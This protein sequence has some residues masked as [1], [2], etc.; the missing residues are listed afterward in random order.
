MAQV[1]DVVR[2]AGE[3]QQHGKADLAAM[4]YAAWI[5]KGEARLRYV[6]RFNLAVLQVESGETVSARKNLEACIQEAPTFH[7]AYFNLG[8]LFEKIKQADDAIRTWRSGLSVLNSDQSD[9]IPTK[10]ALLN[11]LGRLLET[12]KRYEEA[13]DYLRQSLEL[14][15]QQPD[16]IQHWVALRQKQC[17]FPLYEPVAGLSVID[18]EKGTS[19]LSMLAVTDDPARQFIA[20]ARFVARKYPDVPKSNRAWPAR[21]GQKIRLGYVSGDF[22]THAVGL[23]L[24][25]VLEAHDKSRFELF[26]F[27]YSV[28]DG[29]DTRRRLLGCFDEVIDIRAMNDEQAH[30]AI[31]ERRLDIVFDMHGLSSGARPGIFMRRSA[32]LQGSW[33]GYV[34]STSFQHLDFVI[35]DKWSPGEE[36]EL[37]Y[38]EKLVRLDVPFLPLRKESHPHKERTPGPLRLG[39]L[40]NIYKHNPDMLRVWA[41]AIKGTNATLTLLDD[42]PW[43]TANLKRALT[44]FG[45]PQEQLRFIPR[46]GVAD[47]KKTLREFDLYL[48]TFPYN[49]G[50]TAV[51]VIAA[52]TPILTLR[53]RSQIS[54]MVAS[55][56]SYL[57]IECLTCDNMEEYGARLSLILDQVGWSGDGKDIF[58]V[59]SNE[60]HALRFIRAM[61]NQMVMLL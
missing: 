31:L 56:N 20:A 41:N 25:D 39:C 18:L 37:Y 11:Q 59:G 4:A 38:S 46:T 21:T 16:V 26:L 35:C 45:L 50:S 43:A 30:K 29:T 1:E 2:L 58:P 6:A 24:P 61:E 3:L 53:G 28:E 13:E 51:D 27:D 36:A 14:D 9:Y 33:L 34:G 15:S 49:A 54:S 12:M 17:K 10:R 52:G 32:P 44:E 23:L 47:Y 40:N 5:D 42:N 57:E 48:D 60:S 55:I 7:Q 8:L 22:C 19:P